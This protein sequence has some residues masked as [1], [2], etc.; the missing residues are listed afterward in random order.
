MENKKKKI[1]FR[2][3]EAENLG[4]IWNKKL[5]QKQTEEICQYENDQ[6]KAKKKFDF[7]FRFHRSLNDRRE[8][9]SNWQFE[10]CSS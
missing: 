9:C 4:W 8:F 1:F 7:D 5:T 2:K 10:N 3:K 6:K